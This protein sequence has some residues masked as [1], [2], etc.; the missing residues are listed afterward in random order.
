MNN[1]ERLSL[2][3]IL[4]MLLAGCDAKNQAPLSPPQPSSQASPQSDA[5]ELASPAQE[6]P[7]PKVLREDKSHIFL[8]RG[9]DVTDGGVTR[10][11][12]KMAAEGLSFYR[13][14][15]TQNGLIA[16]DDV[17][18]L[19]I[20]C[21][22]AERG[23]TNTDLIKAV[24][25]A[26]A[27][28]PDGFIGEIVIADNGQ[29]QFGT[30]GTGG[31]L[32]WAQPNSSRQ[33]Q[34]TMDVINLL[35]DRMRISG[36]LWDDIAMNGVSEFSDGDMADGFVVEDGVLDTG[37][38]ISYPKFTTQYGT[39]ISF[40]RGVWDETSGQ[41]QS[42]KLKIINMPVLKSHS[43]YHV[44]GAVKN[45]MGVVA[46][47]LTDFRPHNS[48]GSGG[49]GSVMA[50][51]RMPVLNIMDMI[52]V[53]ADKGPGAK[54]DSA[55]EVKSIAASVDPAA[56]DYWAAKNILLPELRGANLENSDPDSNHEGSFGYWLKLSADEIEKRGLRASPAPDEI[57][58][59]E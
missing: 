8:E 54:Y 56:L 48:V 52:W 49:M 32:D 44:T 37:I 15:G 34:S 45:Y 41:Y 39:R 20:N 25:E 31:S 21:Q 3:M 18:L 24:A 16:R 47:R 11:I 55:V 4:T 53:G 42:D 6:P 26:V 17:V 13:T 58:L 27:A 59:I 5:P 36:Y 9:T 29:G 46:N 7:A 28:H 38:Q 35:R 23:G 14:A 30:D 50:E 51:T 22:W 57:L 10:L 43:I 19:K 33:D 12:D 40:K 1:K 2:I